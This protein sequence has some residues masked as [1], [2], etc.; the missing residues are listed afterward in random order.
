MRTPYRDKN[1]NDGNW[2]VSVKVFILSMFGYA[3]NSDAP[4]LTTVR[5]AMSVTA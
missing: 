1:G 3:A 2:I 5:P 4:F